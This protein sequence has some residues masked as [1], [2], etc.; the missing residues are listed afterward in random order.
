MYAVTNDIPVPTTSRNRV[1]GDFAATASVLEVGQSYF[2][3][4]RNQKGSYAALSSKKFPGKKFRLSTVTEA[5]PDG[6]PVSGL[7]VWRTE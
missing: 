5:G 6:T 4:G 1:K 2:A 7:R 3:P